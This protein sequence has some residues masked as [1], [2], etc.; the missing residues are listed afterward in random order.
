MNG[1][2][3]VVALGGNALAPAGERGTIASQ[4]R[5][6]RESP[7]N[8]HGS[9]IVR[10]HR[11]QRASAGLSYRRPH[12]TDNHRFTHGKFLPGGMPFYW[13]PRTKKMQHSMFAKSLGGRGTTCRA[14]MRSREEGGGSAHPFEIAVVVHTHHFAASHANDDRASLQIILP[15]TRP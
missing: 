11:A 4:F 7:A 13:T 10:P 6:T 14:P 1:H 8:G 5:H 2:T 12:R 9:Q 15:A 3:M